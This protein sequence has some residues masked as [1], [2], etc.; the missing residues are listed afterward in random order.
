MPLHCNSS[1]V[2]TQASYQLP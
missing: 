1:Q 2:S